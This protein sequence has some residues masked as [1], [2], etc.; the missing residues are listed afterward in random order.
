MKKRTELIEDFLSGLDTEIDVLNCVDC[1]DVNSFEDVYEAI[2]GNQ[3]FDIDI[4]Y[5]YNAM[6]YL[7]E[8]D[9][10]LYDSLQLAS[11]MGYEVGDLDSEILASL[12]ASREVRNDFNDLQEEIDTFFNDLES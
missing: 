4:I 12:L 8:N 11:E 9:T 3:G 6:K 1:E 10:S 5:Y 7:T 2:D